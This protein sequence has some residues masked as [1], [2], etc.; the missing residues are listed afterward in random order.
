MILSII[1]IQT[2]DK[3]PRKQ[4]MIE[5]FQMTLDSFFKVPPRSKAKPA[6]KPRPYANLPK[7]NN[8]GLVIEETP[9]KK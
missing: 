6:S 9:V 7:T 1:L 2:K 5:T 8:M 4:K 3:N